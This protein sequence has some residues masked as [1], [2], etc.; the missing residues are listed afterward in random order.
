MCLLGDV[1]QLAA[2][3]GQA[4]F[5]KQQFVQGVWREL[6]VCLCGTTRCLSMGWLASLSRPVVWPSCRPVSAFSG[7]LGCVLERLGSVG[8]WIRHGLFCGRFVVLWLARVTASSGVRACACRFGSVLWFG[9]VFCNAPESTRHLG[10]HAVMHYVPLHEQPSSISAPETSISR[11][12]ISPVLQKWYSGDVPKCW[13]TLG[14]C[15]SRVTP[16]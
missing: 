9:I 7:C 5:T 16:Q 14:V 4:L 8:F 11:P 15:V 1:G 3:R 10:H 2:D 12:V 13:V 6:R